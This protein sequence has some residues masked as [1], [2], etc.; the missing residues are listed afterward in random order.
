M[1]W[2]ENLKH[3]IIQNGGYVHPSLQINQ[4]NPQNRF[5]YAQTSIPKNEKIILVSEN[6]CISPNS[7]DPIFQTKELIYMKNDLIVVKKFLEE[8]A[9]KENSFYY[10]YIQ[11][12]PDLSSFHSHP[13]FIAFYNPAILDQWKKI[14]FLVQTL[15]NKCK[16][17]G[18]IL[19][20]FSTHFPIYSE[21]EVIY[22]YFIFMSRAWT[23]SGLVPFADLLQHSIES[24]MF[25]DADPTGG[26]SLV[27]QTNYGENEVIYDNYGINDES[28]MYFN[29][30]FLELDDKPRY[31]HVNLG[32]DF[33]DRK[34]ILG[35]FIQFYVEKL[36]LKNKRYLLTN[37]G[38]STNLLQY[39][40]LK[41][42]KIEDIQRMNLEQENL[43]LDKISLQ[44]DQNALLEIVNILKNPNNRATKEQI[45]LSKQIIQNINHQDP[46]YILARLTLIYEDLIASNLKAIQ[47]FWIEQI[48]L[49]FN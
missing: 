24:Q 47:K 34:S 45:E 36:E 31:F 17:L 30:G 43:G 41:N 49:S 44:N 7:D 33:V 12:L 8:R 10:P 21:E 5:V 39:Y 29:F 14:N 22:S 26:W 18:L 28:L 3:W 1:N 38:L 35:H 42:L 32:F 27:T 20:F 4:E 19:Q 23:K 9:K 6:C 40:R 25:L 13:L 37:L 46:E 11:S 16:L 2:F 15:E 48:G